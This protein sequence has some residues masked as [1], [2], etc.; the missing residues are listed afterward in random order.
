MPGAD[1]IWA[2]QYAN[3]VAFFTASFTVVPAPGA[4]LPLAGGLF[5]FSR[6]RAR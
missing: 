6:R 5:A 1:F 2:P 4:L 3:G